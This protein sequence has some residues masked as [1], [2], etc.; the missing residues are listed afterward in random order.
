M[1]KCYICDALGDTKEH[2]PPKSFFPSDYRFGLVTVPSCSVHNLDNAPDVEYVRNIIVQHHETN[3]VAREHFQGKVIASYLHSPKLLTRTYR[4]SL[5]CTLDGQETR[6]IPTDMVR[7]ER[8][9]EAIAYAVY[10]KDFGKTFSGKWNI[11]ATNLQMVNGENDPAV[12]KFRAMLH[13]I[14]FLDQFVEKPTPQPQVFRYGFF[15]KDE[16]KPI[17]RLQFYGGFN[18][19][20]FP[21]RETG[22]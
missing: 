8:V 18:V 12:I 20:A 21:E 1:E 6:I 7:F 13:T 11:W 9:M 4:D 14:Q 19:Y 10:Y 2:V 3:E 16:E 5:P 22:L 15:P 17:Y